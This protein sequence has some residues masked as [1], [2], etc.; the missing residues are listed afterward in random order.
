MFFV[1]YPLVEGDA[2]P[3]MSAGLTRPRSP[4]ESHCLLNLV[5]KRARSKAL[6]RRAIIDEYV[7]IQNNY[8]L[9]CMYTDIFTKGRSI[10]RWHLAF[11]KLTKTITNTE[12]KPSSSSFSILFIYH[13]VHVR[14][15]YI[16]IFIYILFR[17]YTPW[18]FSLHAII[19][20]HSC[21]CTIFGEIY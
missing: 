13:Y 10:V 6:P 8:M 20:R 11:N 7:Y 2:L 19:S 3:L 18:A 12:K 5:F 4:A 1:C 15:N 17:R 14:K 16:F 21:R 9:A